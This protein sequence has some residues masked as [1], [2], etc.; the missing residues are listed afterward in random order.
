DNWNAVKA[1]FGGNAKSKKM[2]KSMLKQEFSKFKI[3]KAEGLHKSDKSLEVNKNNFVSSDSSVKSLKPKPKD[4]TSC[5]STF[6]VSTSMNEAE[7]ESN[8][9]TPIQEPII[10]QDLPS[11]SSNSFDKNEHT[12]RTSCNKNGYSNKKAGHF[13]KNASS[14]SKLCFVCGSG[15]HLIKDYDLTSKVNIPPARPQ[16]VPTGKPKVVLGKHIENV[17]TGYPRTIVDLIHLHTDDNVADL[18]TKALNG[19]RF[20]HLVVNIGMLNS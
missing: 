1:R 16:R 8:V 4:S 15:T 19:P 11:F 18:L 14:V 5:A 6:S 20:N 9:G 12:S 10:V 17:Y 7:I 3:S 2:R 13:R